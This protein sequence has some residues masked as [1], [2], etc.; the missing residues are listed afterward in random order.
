MSDITAHTSSRKIRFDD[1]FESFSRLWNLILDS[2]NRIGATRSRVVAKWRL[3]PPEI[4]FSMGAIPY[5]LLL[6]EGL[7]TTKDDEVNPSKYAIEAGLSADCCPWNLSAASKILSKEDDSDIDMFLATVGFCDVSSKSWRTMSKRIG[8]P[9][10][11]IEIPQFNFES[12]NNALLFIQQELSSMFNRLS[13]RRGYEFSEE[14]LL[15]EI[16]KGNFIRNLLSDITK[17]LSTQSVPVSALEYFLIQTSAGD[18]LQDPDITGSILNRI[19]TEIE[20]RN[21]NGESAPG[22]QDGAPRIYFVGMAPQQLGFWNLIE[23]C[24]GVSVGCDTYLSLFY[25]LIPEHTN[26]QKELAKWIW[27]MPHNIPSIERSKMLTAYIKKQNPDA[28][29]IGNLVGCRNISQS[30]RFVKETIREELGIP[31]TSLEFGAS[32]EDITLLEP[33]IRSLIDMCK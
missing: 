28:V 15:K 29:I 21:K 9:F 3:F 25:E 22:I 12:E 17:F 5:D 13:R 7:V 32:D 27:R 6:H 24:G 31:V 4:I 1:S 8:R 20:S 19:K 11:S 2:K 14:R 18:Y 16:K 10:Y 33:H 26:V 30:D 23:D